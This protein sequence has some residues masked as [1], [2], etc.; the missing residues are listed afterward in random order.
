MHSPEPTQA[1][2]AMHRRLRAWGQ[3]G[4]TPFA[5]LPRWWQGR[6]DQQLKQ[7]N[8]CFRGLLFARTQGR[9]ADPVLPRFY[10]R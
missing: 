5:R 7:P 6:R 2:P 9:Q 10:Q 3:E 1:A 4:Q 8:V